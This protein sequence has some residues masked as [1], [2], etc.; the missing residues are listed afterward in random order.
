MTV[1]LDLD[2]TAPIEVTREVLI[3]TPDGKG[4]RIK[5]EYIY[6]DRE[7]MAELLEDQLRGNRLLVQQLRQQVDTA[8]D[9][10]DGDKEEAAGKQRA[11]QM[12][13]DATR[14]DVQQLL[15]LA[16]GWNVD[17][18]FDAA[19]L[20]KLCTRYPGAAEAIRQDYRVTMAEGR[21]GN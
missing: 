6:R 19:H 21:L 11:R 20:A 5:F 14:R 8:A 1:K 9:E 13:A 7:A 3:P 16:R 17:A 12:A 2:S 15:Q 4:L 10:G 18:P